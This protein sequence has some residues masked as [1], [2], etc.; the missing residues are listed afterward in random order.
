[1]KPIVNE[2]TAVGK[3]YGIRIAETGAGWISMAIFVRRL[4]PQN[5]HFVIDHKLELIFRNGLYKGLD[6]CSRGER[7]WTSAPWS[8][9]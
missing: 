4:H 1:M 5:A 6:V 2:S 9:L 7:I 3:G 8:R